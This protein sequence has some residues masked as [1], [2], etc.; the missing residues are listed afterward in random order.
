MSEKKKFFEPQIVSETRLDQAQEGFPLMPLL[1]GSGG[2]VSDGPDAPPF[3]NG[4]DVKVDA[5]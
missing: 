2:P 1:G 5:D 4:I 3:Q